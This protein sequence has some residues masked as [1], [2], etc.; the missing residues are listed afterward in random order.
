MK[1]EET[2]EDCCAVIEHRMILVDVCGDTCELIDV[3]FDGMFV[4][5]TDGSLN[6]N[7]AQVPMERHVYRCRIK[8]EMSQPVP[9]TK[10][11]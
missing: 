6:M 2:W 4:E 9:A 3:S 5:I 10:H 8:I 7:K 1:W 11:S